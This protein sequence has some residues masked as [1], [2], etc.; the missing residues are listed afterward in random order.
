M[1]G[2][3]FLQFLKNV[4]LPMSSHRAAEY[5][6]VCLLALAIRLKACIFCVQCLTC[7]ENALE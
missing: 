3:L 7:A 2:V 4:A 5:S 1:D 6:T